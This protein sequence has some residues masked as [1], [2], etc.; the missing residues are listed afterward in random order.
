MSSHG[1]HGRGAQLGVYAIK[2]R[3]RRLYTCE[4]I[5]TPLLPCAIAPG[6]F[7]Q[8]GREK[9]LSSEAGETELKWG[10]KD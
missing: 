8:K 1:T 3:V 2:V 10:P 9:L 6:L 4:Q 7:P 5:R